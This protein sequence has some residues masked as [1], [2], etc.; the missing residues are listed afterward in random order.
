IGCGQGGK[1]S[2]P[3]IVA[4]AVGTAVPAAGA[5]PPPTVAPPPVPGDVV[6]LTVPDTVA[7]PVGLIVP[8]ACA[9]WLACTREFASPTAANIRIIPTKALIRKKFVRMNF[10]LLYAGKTDRTAANHMPVSRLYH[11]REGHENCGK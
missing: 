1:A 2:S 7:P 11:D 3:P 6:A 8:V 5:A 10:L 9:G 4:R